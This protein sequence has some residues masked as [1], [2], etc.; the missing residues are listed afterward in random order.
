MKLT[1]AA[2]PGRQVGG[3]PGI[4]GSIE[5]TYSQRDSDNFSSDGDISH[6]GRLII[7]FS[8]ARN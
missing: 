3:N 6:D 1:I 2:N 7:C 4:I 5:E 8:K